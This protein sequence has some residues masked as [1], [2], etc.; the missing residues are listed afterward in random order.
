MIGYVT[1]NVTLFL[2]NYILEVNF[3]KRI[4][5]LFAAF[6]VM[7]SLSAC[8]PKDTGQ[9]TQSS[10]VIEQTNET[11]EMK[12][13]EPPEDGWTANALLDVTY[14]YNEKIILPC[15]LDTLGFLFNYDKNYEYL[16]DEE[17][18]TISITLFRGED[19]VASAVLKDC[20]GIED[21]ESN[22]VVERLFFSDSLSMENKDNIF[23]NGI[24]LMDNKETIIKKLG[25]PNVE[26][27]YYLEYHDKISQTPIL[28]ISLDDNNNILGILFMS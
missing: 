4:L 2:T 18:N 23:I 11:T 5:S 13:I 24:T 15:K 16:T 27:E 12:T 7:L 28:G 20:Q 10:A 9:D 8:Q 19:S 6:A 21:V 1:I 3:M 26:E 25:V 14:V 17:S 22:T